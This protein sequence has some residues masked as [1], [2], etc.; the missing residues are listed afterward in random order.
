[1]ITLFRRIRQKLIESG[2]ITK[3]L[4]YAIG[5][6]LLVVIGILIALQV[7]NWNEENRKETLKNEIIVKIKSDLNTDL[8]NLLFVRQDLL[9]KYSDGEYLSKFLNSAQPVSEFDEERLNR[10]FMQTGTI[11]QF[12]PIRLAFEEL[13][14]TGAVNRI[15]NDSLKLLLFE[16]YNISVREKGISEQRGRYSGDFNDER[17]TYLDPGVFVEKN[18]AELK[19][20]DYKE[21][22]YMDM[23]L[24][25]EQIIND[26]TFSMYLDRLLGVTIG[27]QYLLRETESGINNILT[28]ID[29]EL[30]IK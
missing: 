23:S 13:V 17:F 29:E 30:R 9:N 25:W 28:L 6:I 4:L 14:S 2:N 20:G 11:E 12:N 26:Q 16:H 3:Y 1:M 21:N 27:Q 7:N 5:E 19:V 10:A 22:P 18:K 8:N 15:E 24:D